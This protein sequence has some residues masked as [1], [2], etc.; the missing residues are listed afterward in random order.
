MSAGSNI[1]PETFREAVRDAKKHRDASEEAD[2]EARR[3]RGAYR[4]RLKHWKKNGIPQDEIVQAMDD[5][6]RGAEAVGEEMRIRAERM[7]WLGLPV[8]FQADI[9][10]DTAK[11]AQS[12]P[13]H[14]E[15]AAGEAG[16]QAGKTGGLR[17]D[18]PY[19]PGTAEH[20]AWDRSFVAGMEALAADMAVTGVKQ[21]STRKSRE[22]KV[23]PIGKLMPS[24]P[25]D[26]AAAH[27]ADAGHA[28]A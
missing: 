11:A 7:A 19:Q 17:D 3:I 22:A 6:E 1:T 10:G 13:Q 5:M 26:I 27:A 9:F 8:G 14:A 2:K 23:K 15:W 12:D 28:T 24:T 25:A 16:L 20:V 21:A 4:A 18:N